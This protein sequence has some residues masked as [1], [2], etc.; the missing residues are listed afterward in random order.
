[1]RLRDPLP[2]GPA[3][4]IG[5]V[6]T[7]RLEVDDEQDQVADEAADGEHLDAEKVGCSDWTPVGAEEGFP[8]HRPSPKRIGLDTV[9]LENALDRRPSEVEAKVHECA[10]KPGVPPGRILAGHRQEL[11]DLVT[12]RGWTPRSAARTTPVV[13]RGD[14]LAVPSKD[15]LRCRK[16][17][18]LGE[19]FPAKRLSLLGKQPSLGLG[20][21]KPLVPKPGAQQAVS[22]RRYSIASPCRRRSQLAS[23]AMRK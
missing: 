3:S 15:G 21:P 4:D 6:H 17:R 1:M 7:A 2:I 12:A 8:R 9:P 20:E 13:L 22:V 5:D 16:R 11:R 14:P 10:A 18:H 19:Q 23:S